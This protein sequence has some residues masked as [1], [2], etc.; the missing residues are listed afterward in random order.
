MANNLKVYGLN[1]TLVLS[2][3]P[4]VDNVKVKK[5]KEDVNRKRAIIEEITYIIENI[6]NLRTPRDILSAELRVKKLKSELDDNVIISNNIEGQLEES[7]K[8][9]KNRRSW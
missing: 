3:M 7:L 4:D 1:N 6:P 2:N 5:E 9:V 8:K